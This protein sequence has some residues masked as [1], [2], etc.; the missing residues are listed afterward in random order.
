MTHRAPI[1]ESEKKAPSA[2]GEAIRDAACVLGE[3][4]NLA[5][6]LQ[7]LLFSLAASFGLY[8]LLDAVGSVLISFFV[9]EASVALL[10]LLLDTVFYLLLAL[11]VLP[12]WFGRWRMAGLLL[13]GKKPDIRELFYYY[14]NATRY[15]RALSIALM[16]VLLLLLPILIVALLYGGAMNVYY[17]A[18][19]AGTPAALA[20]CL[21]AL[22]LCGIAALVLLMAVLSGG[23]LLS[24][25]FVLGNERMPL[26]AAITEAFSAGKR[27]YA[28]I[29]KFSLWHIPRFFLG[30]CTVG[31][32]SLLYYFHLYVLSYLRLCMTLA[33]KE[34]TQH[35]QQ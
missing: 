22:M 27:H 9:E 1:A 17:T 19:Y 12:V 13:Q 7:T 32:L 16:L 30:L 6:M 11:L 34:E 31:V 14:G 15:R 4:G 33:Q 25:G 35:E 3:R 18:L 28:A 23:F 2:A 20:T 26:S 10:S 8:F 24:L 21:L 29:V 5:L